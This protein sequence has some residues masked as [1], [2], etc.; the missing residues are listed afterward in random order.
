MPQDWS[1]WSGSLRFSPYRVVEPANDDEVACVVRRAAAEGQTVRVVGAGHSSSPLVETSDVLV[2]LRKLR[3]VETYDRPSCEATLGAGTTLN[4]AGKA[5]LTHGMAFTNLGDVDYQ[6]VVGAIATGTHGTGKRLPNLATHLIGGRLVTG[7]GDIISFAGEDDPELVLASR[8]SL[9]ATGI[10]TALRL[11]LVPAYQLRKRVWCAHIEECLAHFDELA[12]THRHVDFY[13]YPR[14]DEAK[15]RTMDPAEVAPAELPFA[16]QLSDETDWSNEVI[17]NTRE[18]R[19]EEMEYAVPAEAGRA[20][21]QEVRQRI[22][23]RWRQHVGWR[24]LYRTIAADD[25]YL[26][27]AHGRPTVTISLHQNNTLPF[28][29]FF[30]D[31]EPIFRAHG[32]R[33]HWGKKHTLQADELRSLYPEWD[34]FHEARQRIDPAGVFLNGYLRRLLGV[35]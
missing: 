24:V 16:R 8:V 34:C 10:I 14:S 23:E 15:V 9:G 7:T 13:W 4:A 11:S 12:E 26:S 29:D 32:G 28:W 1:N 31:I 25:A 17:T 3:G 20:C 30:R 18:L 2:S 5:L 6:T 33:P 22:K 27:M 19:F 35:A 21:F